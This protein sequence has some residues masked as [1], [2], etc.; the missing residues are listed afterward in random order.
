MTCV[1]CFCNT[2]L[3][4]QV[5]Q[6]GG[7]R[8][9]KKKY[10]IFF[11]GRGSLFVSVVCMHLLSWFKQC[12]FLYKTTLIFHL[13]LTQP[14]PVKSYMENQINS[15]HSHDIVYYSIF[16]MALINHSKLKNKKENYILTSFKQMYCSQKEI[17]NPVLSNIDTTISLSLFLTHT[18]SLSLRHTFVFLTQFLA[19]HYSQSHCLRTHTLLGNTQSCFL[20]KTHSVLR[21]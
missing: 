21:I 1:F 13:S 19:T 2:S 4:F 7:R 10:I 11:W 20:G 5:S 14:Q 6:I 8:V 9:L 16:S 15:D 17:K 18:H 12:A 3:Q